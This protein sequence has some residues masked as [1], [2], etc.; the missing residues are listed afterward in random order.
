MAAKAPAPGKANKEGFELF[1]ERVKQGKDAMWNKEE[2]LTA[3]H[4]QKQVTA[5]IIGIV[6]GVLPLTG[7]NGFLTFAIAQG[8][9]TVIFYRGVLRIDEEQHGGVAE[10]LVEG[11][12]TFSAVFVLVWVLAYNVAH[13]PLSATIV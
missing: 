7:L 10:V 13:V 8:L 4:W 1:L 12:P 6:C 2:L 9:C 5:L 3:M 11:F